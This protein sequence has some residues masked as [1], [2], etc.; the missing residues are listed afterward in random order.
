[1]HGYVQRIQSALVHG[2]ALM[3]HDGRCPETDLSTR[4]GVNHFKEGVSNESLDKL[5][6]SPTVQT[7]WLPRGQDLPDSEDDSV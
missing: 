5:L 7:L 3:D 2:D 4:A 1:M 6:F